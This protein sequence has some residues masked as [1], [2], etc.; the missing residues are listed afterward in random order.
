MTLTPDEAFWLALY[1][2]FIG[3]AKAIKQYKLK[4]VIKAEPVALSPA[5]SVAGIM[6]AESEKA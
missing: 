2:A 4:G 3:I 1:A 5:D 6:T